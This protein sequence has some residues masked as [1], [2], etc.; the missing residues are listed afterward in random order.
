MQYARKLGASALVVAA[1]F[2]VAFAVLVSSSTPVEA[3]SPGGH[4]DITYPTGDLEGTTDLA[5]N[6]PT[7]AS[8]RLRIDTEG[9]TA[10]GSFASGGRQVLNCSD[11]TACDLDDTESSI[12]IRVNI[13]EDSPSGELYVQ[14]YT[15]SDVGVVTVA[16]EMVITVSAAN[17]VVLIRTVPGTTGAPNPSHTAIDRDGSEF[18]NIQ[19]QLVNAKGNG[20]NGRITVT[21]TRGVLNTGPDGDGNAGTCVTADATATAVASPLGSCA[22]TTAGSG[23]DTG[24]ATVSLFGNN[25]A[26]EAKVTFIHLGLSH[27]VDIVLHGSAGKIS[28]DSD[29]STVELGG[30]FYI[31]VSITDAAD[32]AVQ[33][34]NELTI[35]KLSGPSD[36]SNAIQP[37]ANDDNELAA[38]TNADKSMTPLCFQQLPDPDNAGSF[39]EAAGT[40]S[41]GVCVIHMEAQNPTDTADDAARGEHTVLIDGGFKSGADDEKDQVSVSVNVS[42]TPETITT[43]APESVEPLSETKITVTVRDDAG[44]LVGGTNISVRLVDGGGLVEGLEPSSDSPK[45]TKDGTA[46]FTYFAPATEGTAVFVI[47]AGAGSAKKRESVTVNIASPE[48]EVI[49][50]DPDDAM[51]EASSPWLADAPAGAVSQVI[52]NGGSVDELKAALSECGDGVAAHA[53]V[54]G[55]W[56]SYIPGAAIAAANAPFNAAF[57]EGIPANT[58]LQVTNCN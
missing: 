49:E 9:S 32:N 34:Y 29:V 1:A 56:V 36:D 46:S 55:G 25:L 51:P 15:R 11:N 30:K 2:A 24:K 53:T 48:P 21:T 6:P 43:D 40:N 39:L 14:R 4:M 35:E 22:T 13:D 12:K 38:R 57:A 17:P 33:G 23:D 37:V 7:R 45:R 41:D 54:D 5:A 18:T 27:S 28:A 42:G 52:F 44:E 26:G 10:S 50:P 20:V 19:V 47:D 8:V 31:E 58:V 3:A 16:A